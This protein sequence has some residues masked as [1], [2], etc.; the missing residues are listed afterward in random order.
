MRI[1]TATPADAQ[2]LTAVHVA[3]WR[4][5]YRGLVPDD[6]LDA[7]PEDRWRAG[8]ERMLADQVWPTLL[9]ETDDGGLVG[10]VAFRPTRDEDADP[11]STGEVTGLYVAPEHWDTG[12][13][14][15]LMAAAV[16]RLQAAGYRRATLWVLAGNARGRR[17]YER[18]GWTPDGTA[19]ELTLGGA[20]L[21]EVRYRREL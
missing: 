3:T 19:K 10:F 6:F 16:E 21:T 8:W 9:A 11:T 4:V 12:V 13:G 14:R 7:L 20:V 17:F 1:R 18:A 5:A 15:A 2:A